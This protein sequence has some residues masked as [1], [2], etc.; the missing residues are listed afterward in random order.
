MAKQEAAPR[1]LSVQS[2][3]ATSAPQRGDMSGVVL[4][5]ETI[6][7]V[8]SLQHASPKRTDDASTLMK[9]CWALA[10]YLR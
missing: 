3:S 9:A 6:T 5:P 1:Q 8:I 2:E 10:S 4:A 7:S